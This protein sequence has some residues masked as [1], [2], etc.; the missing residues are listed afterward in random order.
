MGIEKPSGQ[1]QLEKASPNQGPSV[2][3]RCPISRRLETNKM[4]WIG[5]QA[6]RIRPGRGG[7]GQGQKG[8][9]CHFKPRLKTEG[10]GIEG[11][12]PK[13]E[14]TKAMVIPKLKKK[15]KNPRP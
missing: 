15:G 1:G 11:G 14:K 12:A 8:K 7:R 3:G 5:T 6:Q 4:K 9:G 2:P 10:R 13:K